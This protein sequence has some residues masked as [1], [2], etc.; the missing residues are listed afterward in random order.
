MDAGKFKM[1]VN[2]SHFEN[3]PFAETLVRK[4]LDDIG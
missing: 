1:V 2:G 4:N 3:A